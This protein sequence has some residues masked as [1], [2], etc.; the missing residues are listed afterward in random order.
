MSRTA[1]ALI[2]TVAFYLSAGT[3][4]AGDPWKGASVLPKDP[5]GLTLR[6]IASRPGNEYAGNAYQIAWP[7]RVEKIDGQWILIGDKGGYI[8]PPIKGWVRK[9]EMLSIRDDGGASE[10][11]PPQYLS[12]KM[13]EVTDAGT[14]A[15]LY[16]LRG[17]TWEGQSEP[18]IAMRDYAA[19]IRCA[20]GQTVDPNVA[21][22]D[23][24]G[25]FHA[26]QGAEGARDAVARFP[27]LADA[28]LR[29]ARLSAKSE[30]KSLA[31]AASTGKAST[32]TGASGSNEPWE[33]YFACADILFRPESSPA[34][35][36]N[37]SNATGSGV[38]RLDTDWAD[39]LAAEYSRL[40]AKNLAVLKG[41][42]Q[43][44]AAPQTDNAADQKR[45]NAMQEIA[46]KADARYKSA[47]VANPTW[48]DAYLGRG[49]LLLA[50]SEA[51]PTAKGATASQNSRA[52][53]AEAI[54]QFTTAIQL[55]PKSR[56]AYRRRGEAYRS[57]ANHPQL[58]KRYSD[59]ARYLSQAAQSA[60]SASQLGK[61]RDPACLELL[62]KVIESEAEMY[63][64]LNAPKN[65]SNFYKQASYYWQEA[66]SCP[67]ADRGRMQDMLSQCRQRARQRQV[68]VAEAS[69]GVDEA[70]PEP[71]FPLWV[72]GSNLFRDKD[73]E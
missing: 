12:N 65:A 27:G 28:Y 67:N 72:P 35:Q 16:W 61:D 69:R 9:E 15:S 44:S 20:F 66:A 22:D 2:V 58:K 50:K 3:A 39:A 71:E 38:P 48:T 25:L 54:Q 40:V 30:E 7:A 8:I 26:Q 29:L 5:K 13:L 51:L 64:Q 18:Q 56:E 14:L 17:I 62:A 32:A 70:A 43:G 10:D 41:E 59:R 49:R 46:D 55:D 42:S 73:K 53:Y 6:G 47:L 21:S 1:V 36:F 45:F 19:S 11:D 31:P 37:Q 4:R 57:L 60:D 33:I 63:D 68:L 52:L 23:V 34:H 24:S